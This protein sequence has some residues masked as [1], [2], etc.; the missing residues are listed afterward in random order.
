[1]DNDEFI[2]DSLILPGI[3]T[4]LS[5]SKRSIFDYCYSTYNNTTYTTTTTCIPV[6][7][8]VAASTILVAFLFVGAAF[9]ITQ[10]GR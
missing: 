9:L 2:E 8:G 1:M 10:P 6:G 4:H 7:L 5:R 3:D